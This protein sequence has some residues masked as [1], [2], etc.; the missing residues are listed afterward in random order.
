V[1]DL[2]DPI[3]SS[4][5]HGGLRHDDG[6]GLD[7][8]GQLTNRLEH[9]GEVGMPIAAP[10]RGADRDEHG[11]RI[12]HRG[13]EV[14]R[15]GQPVTLDIRL[16]D[17][18]QAGFPDRHDAGIQ[19]VDLGGILVDAAHA[20]AKVGEAGSGHEPDIAGADHRNAHAMLRK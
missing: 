19:S 5:R 1:Q 16:D 8:L 11:F 20:M 13:R 4:D 12:A 3:P 2:F 7:D 17:G 10:R 15:E 18:L 14:G 6:A 9:E